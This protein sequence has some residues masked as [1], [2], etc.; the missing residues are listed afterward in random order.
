MRVVRTIFPGL[1]RPDGSKASLTSSNAFVIL[2]PNCHST[3]SLRTSP[4]PCSPENAPLKRRTHSE[5]S[6][7]MARI[8][9]APS[10]R[11]SR[12]GRTCKV[13]TDAWAY[14]VPWVPCLAKISVSLA[15][16]SARCSRGTAQ[17]SIKDT[18]L[19][20][21]LSDIMML[22]PALRTSH[23]AD[24]RADSVNFTVAFGKPWSLI[25]TSRASSCW[26]N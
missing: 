4:S 16:Y 12:M 24:C 7:A 14:Q 20:S 22:R 19:P 3:H 9:A 25:K 23:R 21:P 15:V 18:G 5:A 6:C 10:R 26:L 11:I 1:S 2:G 13:P 17:S 8:L